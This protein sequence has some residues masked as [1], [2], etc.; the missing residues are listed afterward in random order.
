[1]AQL[2][3]LDGDD[4]SIL[5]VLQV[6]LRQTTLRLFRIPVH[7]LAPRTYLA[8]LVRHLFYAKIFDCQYPSVSFSNANGLDINSANFNRILSS[9]TSVQDWTI[10]TGRSANR[11]SSPDVFTIG[12]H[13]K[14]SAS[15][16]R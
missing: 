7:N 9:V 4:A 15:H 5:I 10:H 11:G 8:S 6:L 16:V 14:H 2:A 13:P 12:I 1:M 3:F